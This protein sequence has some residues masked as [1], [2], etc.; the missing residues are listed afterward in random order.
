MRILHRCLYSLAHHHKS[1]RHNRA[2][3]HTH[4]RAVHTHRPHQWVNVKEAC[5]YSV[6][7]HIKWTIPFNRH[8]WD[9]TA[10]HENCC[11]HCIF[12]TK[13]NKLKCFPPLIIVILAARQRWVQRCKQESSNKTEVIEVWGKKITFKN[14]TMRRSEHN[15]R[16]AE[17]RMQRNFVEEKLGNIPYEVFINTRAFCS[18]S[19]PQLNMRPG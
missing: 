13:W 7:P 18:H 5:Y 19:S 12:I 6:S 17:M 2:C 1:H 10:M 9:L 15:P 14:V 8:T 3:K 16:D 11:L 4:A